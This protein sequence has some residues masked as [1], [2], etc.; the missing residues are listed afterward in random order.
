VDAGHGGAD[1]SAAPDAPAISPLSPAVLATFV[2]TF[3]GV[4][5]I[6]HSMF[7]FPLLLSLPVSFASGLAVG[8]VVFIVFYRLFQ[9]VQASSEVSMAAVVGLEA[10]VTV[11]IPKEG[12]GQIAYVSQG[13][14][15]TSPA[16]SEEAV[17][18]PRHASVR[19]SKV[20]GNTYYVRPLLDEQLRDLSEDETAPEGGQSDQEG[21]PVGADEG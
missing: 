13:G 15:F 6:T 12:I 5:V 10:E 16:R 21:G 9:T 1:F 18:I 7:R 8:G 19:I 14:R 3:G 4:G 17:E 20:V 11:A 2:T